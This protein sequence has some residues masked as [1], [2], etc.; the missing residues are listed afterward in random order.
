[1]EREL[2]ALHPRGRAEA[3]AAT[4]HTWSACGRVGRLLH[5]ARLPLKRGRAFT[6]HDDMSKPDVVI[7]SEA[8]ARSTGLTR[9]RSASGSS[10]AT[11]MEMATIVGVVEMPD[12][13][14]TWARS[15]APVAYVPVNQRPWSTMTLVVRTAGDPLAATP[16]SVRSGRSIRRSPRA[17]S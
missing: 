13:T 6:R 9:I 16:D 8:L 17:T 14:P 7:V 12:T 15:L 1:M 3:A 11:D 10:I 2:D 4:P 5:R